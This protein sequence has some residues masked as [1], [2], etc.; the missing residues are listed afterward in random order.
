MSLFRRKDK[1][2]FDIKATIENFADN[3]SLDRA[4]FVY[5]PEWLE[6]EYEE[7]GT[8]TEEPDPLFYICDPFTQRRFYKEG[9]IAIGALV[10]ANTL[11]FERGK[12]DCPAAYIYSLDPYYMENQEE[13]EALAYGLFDTK[14]EQGYRPSIQKLADL[15]ADEEERI[16]AYKLPRDVTEG[17]NVYF[18][19]VLV[20]RDHLPKR[21]II[22]NL[23]PMLVLE[24]EQPD[25]MILPHWYWE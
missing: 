18:T 3:L 19:T 4:D 21:K 8:F 1:N 9:K 6:P 12:D 15:M 23:I 13:L 22:D 10:Q 2:K 7:D 17:R 20:A 25:A 14:G 5:C 16:F 24:G 11:L